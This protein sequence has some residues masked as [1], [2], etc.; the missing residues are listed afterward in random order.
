M[1]SIARW[2]LRY[3]SRCSRPRQYLAMT[4][5]YLSRAATMYSSP[6]VLRYALCASSICSR[7]SSHDHVPASAR[8][9]S[10]AGTQP[11]HTTTG[12]TRQPA[13]TDAQ[14]LTGSRH[15]SQN[16]LRRPRHGCGAVYLARARAGRARADAP[17]ASAASAPLGGTMRGRF[18][19]IL[20]LR[21]SDSHSR[22]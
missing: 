14:K 20:R 3:L 11:L 2:I 7:Q 12:H 15:I 4:T 6:R 1:R 10:W 22:A 21:M 13:S 17:S 8:P 9:R 5:A 18:E 16:E 19:R